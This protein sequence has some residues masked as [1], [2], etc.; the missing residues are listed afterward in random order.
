MIRISKNALFGTYVKYLKENGLIESEMSE[1]ILKS[2]IAILE[3]FNGVR[4][5]QSLAHDNHILNYNESV[6]I[7]NNVS[8][9]IRFID[10]IEQDLSKKMK[11]E[12]GPELEW[13][14]IEFN[15]EEIE[16]A[17]DEWMQLQADIARGK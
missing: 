4:N 17:G 7:F 2:S 1:R 10:L 14:D 13:D 8:N 11:V 9:T 15:K 6:L 16:A 3:S 12:K 5:N